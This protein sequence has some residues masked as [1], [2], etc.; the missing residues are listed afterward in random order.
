MTY[1]KDGPLSPVSFIPLDRVRPAKMHFPLV[2]SNNHSLSDEVNR[3][4]W[5]ISQNTKYA[6]GQ[7]GSRVE[8]DRAKVST[9]IQ[10]QPQ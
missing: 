3:A 6:V 5:D 9:V 2:Q 1:F 4:I 8:S 7:R 10:Q